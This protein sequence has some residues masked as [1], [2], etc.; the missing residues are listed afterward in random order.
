M[1]GVIESSQVGILPVAGQRILGQVVRAAGEEVHFLRQ[2][3]AHQHGRGRFDHD[4]DLDVIAEGNA[5][6]RQFLLHTLTHLLGFLHFPHARNHREHDAQLAERGSPEQRTQLRMED[7][8]PVQAD[9]QRT[10]AHGRVLFLRQIEITD[11]LVCANVQRPDHDFLPSH[12]AQRL[13]IGLELV[14]LRG[15]VVAIQVQEFTPEQADAAGV[16]CE[17]C[18][19]IVRGA[20]VAV[21]PD[22]L[23]VLRLVRLTLQL[24]EQLPH[25]LLLFHLPEQAAARVLIRVDHN[26]ARA[27]VDDD[28]P[29]FIFRFQL[30]ADADNGRNAHRP[31]QD[32]RM[33]GVRSA[34]G[35]EA[36]NPALVQLNR[37]TG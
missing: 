27:A 23:A 14:I 25:L 11:L 22:R 24:L 20:D 17:H 33:A 5:F 26:V 7:L 6:L 37:F 34:F 8:G 1:M 19:N 35:H 15:I 10:V 31:G 29:A 36:E 30:V 4:A 3:V 18:R 28:L 12:I 9:A 32:R 21:D 2:P 16:V 13:L